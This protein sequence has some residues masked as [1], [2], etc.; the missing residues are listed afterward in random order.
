[1]TRQSTS[2]PVILS[3]KYFWGRMLTN[4]VG[5]K[6]CAVCFGTQETRNPIAIDNKRNLVFFIAIKIYKAA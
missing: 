1:M 2:P 6:D 3:T 4:T 5:R